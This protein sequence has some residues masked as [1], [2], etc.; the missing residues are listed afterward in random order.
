[1]TALATLN[2]IS[3]YF[4]FDG[5]PLDAGYLYFGAVGQNPVTSPQT[6][7][8]DAAG[9][10]PAAQPIRTL[11]GY[12][13]RGGAP[14]IVYAAA[15]YSLLVNDKAGRQVFYAPDSSEFG[16][17]LVINADLQLLKT[18]LADA[19][20]GS[21][22][23]GMAGYQSSVLYD[24]FSAGY[25]LDAAAI[26][27]DSWPDVDPTGA[28]D[29]TSAI[30]DA[31]DQCLS[32]GCS[33]VRLRRTYLIDT[34][35]HASGVTIDA[36]GATI[37]FVGH[38]TSH[39]PMV[40]FGSDLAAIENAHII[41][42]DWNGNASAQTF[43]NEEW[44]HGFFI[45]GSKG[46]SV[47]GA[48]VHDVKGDCITIGYDNRADPAN[49]NTVT[50]CELYNPSS[51]P[52][53]QAIAITY[54]NENVIA[55]NRI[56][57]AIDLEINNGNYECK[58]NI[59]HGN[60]G[61]DVA[62][63]LNRPRTSTLYIA[64]ASK[65][66]NAVRNF[67]NIVTDNVCQG[68]T[69]QYHS[70]AIITGNIIV[71]SDPAQSYLMDIAGCNYMTIASNQ[72]IANQ[73]VA[74]GL[75]SIIRTRGCVALNV[76]GNII[77]GDSSLIPFHTYVPTF[78]AINASG[79]NFQDNQTESGYYRAG[80]AQRATEYARFR[81]DQDAAGS[82]TMTQVAGVNCFAT[83]SRS[84]ANFILAN[85]G[86]AGDA[87]QIELQRSCNKTAAAA[88]NMPDTNA[89]SYTASGSSRTVTVF[90]S[91]PAAGAVSLAA[92]SFAAAG[93]SGTF[94]IDVWF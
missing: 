52:Q 17:S 55:Y 50:D 15:D 29:C 34:L 47:R 62:E 38:S 66:T 46:C 83:I 78:N 7:Y 35:Q 59:V 21:N 33:I 67:G 13:M 12:P 36:R 4:D 54:G 81:I 75:A 40:R 88:T 93:N 94:F 58:N 82:L 49:G 23:A 6:V 16:N 80:G 27:I 32:L 22:G 11:H 14:A 30:Q 20:D 3:Q 48:K 19:T 45:Y 85:V 64:L 8:W 61:R 68:M 1:M 63:N 92:F 44:S 60:R 5:S 10:Q 37:N 42:G 39:N 25:A 69:L 53:R 41:G 87:Y 74:T 70:G 26:D 9:T 28:T 51:S 43:P 79:H 90:T 65:N 89:Y 18:R 73:T 76:E 57:G 56:S 31:I 91:T 2:P 71:G 24:R 72:F 77:S 86:N 84:G